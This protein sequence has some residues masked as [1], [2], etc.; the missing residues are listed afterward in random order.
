MESLHHIIGK[1]GAKFIQCFFIKV[2]K[3]LLQNEI[4]IPNLDRF[5]NKQ[6]KAKVC[7]I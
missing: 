4:K 5:L 3:E 7:Q 6:V 2:V 1:D